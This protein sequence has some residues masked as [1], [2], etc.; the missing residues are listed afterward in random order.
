[1]SIWTRLFGKRTKTI[2]VGPTVDPP[3]EIADDPDMHPGEWKWYCTE[4]GCDA[5]G[6]GEAQL[7]RRNSMTH[8]LMTGHGVYGTVVDD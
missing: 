2:T 3:V 7:M 6:T 4:P 5:E 1:M 8:C